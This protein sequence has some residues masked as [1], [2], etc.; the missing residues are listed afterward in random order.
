MLKYRELYDYILGVLYKLKINNNRGFFSLK[1]IVEKLSN[2]VGPEEVFE[3][4]KYL[5][6]EG[7][8][9]AEFTLGDV[10]VELK[11]SG[12]IYIENKDEDF[13][14]TFD[15]YLKKKN[16]NTNNEKIVSKLSKSTIKKSRQPIMNLANEII[17]Y[18]KDTKELK[19]TDLHRDAK[20][21]KLELEKENIDKEVVLIKMNSLAE[22]QP[23][24]IKSFELRNYIIHSIDRL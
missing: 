18:F 15:T 9:R 16:F 24:S 13:L 3:I 21:L 23:L 5:E 6:A 2:E 12:I 7:F 14:P 11:P 10:F 4:G 8:V 22:F 1:E 19:D 20:I 17:K